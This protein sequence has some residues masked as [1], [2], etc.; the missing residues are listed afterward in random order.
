MPVSGLLV[1]VMVTIIS[2]NM[3]LTVRVLLRPGL[4]METETGSVTVIVI[5]L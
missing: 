5:V 4:Y 2:L 3:Y 1:A